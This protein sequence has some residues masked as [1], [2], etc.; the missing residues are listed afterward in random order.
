[1]S[2]LYKTLRHGSATLVRAK[3]GRMV[4]SASRNGPSTKARLQN[5]A[6]KKQSVKTI[7]PERL[8]MR[9]SSK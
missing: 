8:N 1:M 7:A 5:W 9:T 6:P 4:H 3:A 2:R